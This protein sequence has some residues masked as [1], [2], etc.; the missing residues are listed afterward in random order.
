MPT[1]F[2]LFPQAANQSESESEKPSLC[3]VP[4]SSPSV[5][6]DMGSDPAQS[7]ALT[8]SEDVDKEDEFGYS[9]SKL[10]LCDALNY[11]KF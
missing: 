3:D 7:S 5:F 2:F 4:P 10:A 8:V 9:W 11:M 6:P 1:E